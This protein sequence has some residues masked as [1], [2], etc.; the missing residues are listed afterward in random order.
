MKTTTLMGRQVTSHVNNKL[1][2]QVSP[3]TK[4]ST[5]GKATGSRLAQLVHNQTNFQ[6]CRL[7]TV[8]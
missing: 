3:K 6:G 1:N 4:L 7:P 2:F 8:V 5:V